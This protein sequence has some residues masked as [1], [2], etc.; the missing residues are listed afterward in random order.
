MILVYIL[1]ITFIIVLL[2]SIIPFTQYLYYKLKKE[3]NNYTFSDELYN[4][5]Y[6]DIYIG[7]NSVNTKDFEDMKRLEYS[8]ELP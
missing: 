5:N 6:S 2:S 7:C 8:I 4:R 3:K 1:L